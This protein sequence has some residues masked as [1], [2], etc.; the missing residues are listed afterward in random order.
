LSIVEELRA[1]IAAKQALESATPVIPE[2]TRDL[3]LG[4]TGED[5][6]RLQIFLNRDPDTRVALT[7]PGSLGQETAF[8][9]ELTQNA[10][11]RFQKKH[12]GPILKLVGYVV[13]SGNWDKQT[14][15]RANEI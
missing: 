3:T 15:E 4:D 7:G 1:L 10:V 12:A 11:K 13:L 6:R 5:V 14:R 8:F 9:G 2:F